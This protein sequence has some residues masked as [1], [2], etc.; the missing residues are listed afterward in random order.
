MTNQTVGEALVA[1]LK[2]RGVSC[3]FGIPGVH[4]VELYRGLA[5]S[6]IRH[7]TPRH[8]QGAG[9]MA[10]GYA[11]ASGKPGVAFVITGPGLTNTLT[12]MAQARADSVPMLVVSGVNETDTLGQGYGH[13]HELPDQHA[14]AKTVALV[15]E[16]VSLPGDLD[17]ALERAFATCCSE[18]PG[19]THIQIP[20]E[21]AGHAAESSPVAKTLPSRSPDGDLIRQASAQLLAAKRIVI[22]A[23]GGA[24]TGAEGL[25]TLAERLDAPVVQTVNA[26]GLMHDHPLTV[27]ASPSLKSVRALIENADCVLALGTELGPTDYDMYATG[28]MP[29]MPGLIRVD[30]CPDQLARHD[31]KIAIQARTDQAIAALLATLPDRPDQRDGAGRAKKTRAAAFEEIG[32]DY[33]AQVEILA[34]MR[35]TVPNALIVG[36]ST[37]P[38]YAGNLYYDHDRPGGWFNAA[39]GYGALGYGIPAAIGA[40]IAAPQA[41]VICIAGDGGAQFSLPEIMAAV[42]HNLHITFVL[43]NNHGYGEIAASVQ[44][45]GVEVIGCDPTPPDFAATAASFGIPYERVS[46]NPAEIAAALASARTRN[47]PSILEIDITGNRPDQE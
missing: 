18:R 16:H 30:V 5:A 36:D 42:D 45:A 6:G 32:P 34:A 28:K 19:P 3:V 43:W 7:V 27:P 26:R 11:R 21:V 25:K 44:D 46:Q 31:T 14:L 23:G 47:C 22:L 15:S 9:F 20:L 24:K 39:T 17:P 35:A 13:L 12:P 2:Q 37:Q 38:I 40:G 1:G 33:R 10:D 8:E 41:P 29:M 4:T